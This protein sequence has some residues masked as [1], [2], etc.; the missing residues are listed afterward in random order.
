MGL[1]VFILFGCRCSESLRVLSALPGAFGWTMRCAP[2]PMDIN[3]KTRSITYRHSPFIRMPV[4]EFFMNCQELWP[5]GV[6]SLPAANKCFAPNMHSNMCFG[7][8]VRR[9]LVTLVASLTVPA[10]RASKTPSNPFATCSIT[11][12]KGQCAFAM[13]SKRPDLIQDACRKL[14]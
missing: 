10:A 5:A 6:S 7:G 12:T 1:P 4:Q 11:N 9:V 14:L 3:V 13:E 8:G 2:S